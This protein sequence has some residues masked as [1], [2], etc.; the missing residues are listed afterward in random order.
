MKRLSL[1]I[2]SRG[3]DRQSCC[4]RCDECWRRRSERHQFR[5]RNTGN[6]RRK[7]D[8]TRCIDVS[9]RAS[10]VSEHYYAHERYGSSELSG[11]M[12]RRRGL[13]FPQCPKPIIQT[14]GELSGGLDPWQVP[15]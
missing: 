10:D 6:Y 7:N 13:A 2:E 1:G 4:S 5:L 12:K 15:K 9:Q 3:P 8:I 11:M 14:L